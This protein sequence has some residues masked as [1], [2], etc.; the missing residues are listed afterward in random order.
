MLQALRKKEE[1]KSDWS[2]PQTPHY[3]EGLKNI[4][5]NFNGIFETDS[6][7]LKN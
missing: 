6:H 7:H 1:V 2:V 4:V 3:S 5:D